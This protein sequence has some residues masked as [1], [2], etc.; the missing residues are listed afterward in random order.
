MKSM[1]GKALLTTVAAVA[2]A[3]V[4]APAYAHV[5]AGGGGEFVASAHEPFLAGEQH[6]WAETSHI[7]AAGQQWGWATSTAV[8]GGAEGIAVID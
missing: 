5:A 8:A 1:L 4:S 6:G 7:F 3:G 2:L